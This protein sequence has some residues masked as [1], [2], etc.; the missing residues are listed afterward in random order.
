MA[1]TLTNRIAKPLLRQLV[2]YVL[3]KLRGAEPLIEARYEQA[4][5][6]LALLEQDARDRIN[7]LEEAMVALAAKLGQTSVLASNI[8][9]KVS[10]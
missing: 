2:D 8:A 5:V 1:D 9:R 3:A 7:H 6:E 4:M 10:G